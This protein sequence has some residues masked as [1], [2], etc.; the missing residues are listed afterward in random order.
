MSEGRP[1]FFV[2]RVSFPPERRMSPAPFVPIQR[3]FPGAATTERIGT[4]R[5]AAASGGTTNR[6]PRSAAI[7]PESVP[8][9]SV[10]SVVRATERTF[11][12]GS[13]SRAP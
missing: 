12:S 5:S 11:S 10:P 7:P 6:S 13:P 8:T 3:T 1:S 2:K 4:P 9:Q